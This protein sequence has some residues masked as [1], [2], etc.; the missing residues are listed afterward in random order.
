MTTADD[1]PP[2]MKPVS[3]LAH[4]EYSK[5][6]YIMEKTIA[7]DIMNEMNDKLSA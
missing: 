1:V 5:P 7:A 3:A 6:K 4:D 2:Q